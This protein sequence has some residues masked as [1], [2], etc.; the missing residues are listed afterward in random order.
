L[1]FVKRLKNIGVFVTLIIILHPFS[2][3][4]IRNIYNP[5]NYLD[6]NLLII[7]SKLKFPNFN[8]YEPNYSILLIISF[9]FSFTL[10]I[11]SY[12]LNSQSNDQ[13]N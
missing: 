8:V 7:G 12:I 1:V 3:L 2:L 10:F 9:I 11:A 4:N 5:F 13:E 6:L